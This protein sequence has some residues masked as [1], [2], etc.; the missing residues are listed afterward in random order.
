MT[1]AM[2]DHILNPPS[3]QEDLFDGAY[4]IPWD[5]PAFSQ[6]MLAEH[7]SQDHPLASRGAGLISR[8]VSWIEAQ[9]GKGSQRTILDL[10]CGPGLYLNALLSQGFQGLGIDFSPASIIYARQH[11]PE[12]C[13][14]RYIHGDLRHTSFGSGYH[15]AMMLYGE[16]NVFSP[17]EIRAIL[18]KV[19]Q[20][21]KPGGVL[22]LEYQRYAALELAGK[23]PP[24]W[25]RSGQGV[26][27][28][29]SEHPH[30]C[31]TENHWDEAQSTAQQQ[32]HIME[33]GGAVY[34]YRSTSK[35]W[36]RLELEALLQEMGFGE[37]A[38]PDDWPGEGDHLGL[39]SGVKLV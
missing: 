8:Q 35:A 16:M 12:G 22:L 10:G 21:L 31:L 14:G 30:L 5:D 27:G 3:I 15:M 33:A 2:I 4:K 37:I 34:H 23:A 32:F 1:I 28:I 17:V 39:I 7:L 11:Q 13:Q 19:R 25:Y 26:A 6:R 38:Y 9:L 36:R 20:S 29:F 24:S 18:E